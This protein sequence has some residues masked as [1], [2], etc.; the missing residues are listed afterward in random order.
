MTQ[1]KKP[2]KTYSIVVTNAAT[3]DLK[4]LQRRDLVKVDARIQTLATDPRPKDCK[5]LADNIYRNQGW[6]LSHC[7]RYRRRQTRGGDHPGPRQEE[8]L[9]EST[10]MEV[11]SRQAEPCQ[12]GPFLPADFSRDAL[13]HRLRRLESGRD[14]VLGERIVVKLELVQRDLPP[15]ESEREYRLRVGGAS[16]P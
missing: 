10:C 14:L 12:L 9:Q 3:R 5:K 15:A 11:N 4:R 6:K 8:C 13:P 2:P 16:N 7:V 1:Q